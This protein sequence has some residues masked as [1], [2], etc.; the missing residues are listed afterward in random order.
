MAD[1]Q[2][3]YQFGVLNAFRGIGAP[4]IYGI[5]NNGIITVEVELNE[6]KASINGFTSK[7][8]ANEAIALAQRACGASSLVDEDKQFDLAVAILSL[9]ASKSYVLQDEP[10]DD[11]ADA[12]AEQNY[13]DADIE[14]WQFEKA[15]VSL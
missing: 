10:Q 4:S 1:T 7:V 15:G 13:L 9:F 8:M 6:A 11:G 2:S 14:A 5:N 12:I 3:S